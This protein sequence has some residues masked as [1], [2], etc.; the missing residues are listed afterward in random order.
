[1]DKI[2]KT[3]DIS[4]EFTRAVKKEKVFY[5]VKS[6]IPMREDYNF[7]ADLLFLPTTKGGYKFFLVVVDIANNE[8]DIKPLKNKE[9]DNVLTAMKTI[10]KRPHFKMPYASIATDS[11]TEFMSSFHKYLHKNNMIHKRSVSYRHTQTGNLKSLNKQLW[12]VFIGYMNMKEEK[13]GKLY[14]K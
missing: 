3:L 13:S 14:K 5:K 2:L 9:A 4:E 1:M 6:N 8:F 10:F 11:G 12:R 7:M